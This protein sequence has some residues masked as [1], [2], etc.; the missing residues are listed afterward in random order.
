VRIVT[1]VTRYMQVS[2][3]G[4]YDLGYQAVCPKYRRLVLAGQ[5]A[6][7]CEEL[8]RAKASDHSWRI[9]PDSLLLFVK[10]HQSGSPFRIANQFK[11]LTSRR[12]RAGFPYL[13]SRLP[14]LWSRSYCEATVGAV[15]AEAV[16][17]CTGT[18]DGRPWRKERA[19]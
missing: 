14:A 1:R 6:G 10:A 9:M 3:G 18:Q 16:C 4:V 19:R 5:V 8:I 12:L 17:R 11:G 2:A 13:R 7:R 15:S